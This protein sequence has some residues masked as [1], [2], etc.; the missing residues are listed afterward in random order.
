MTPVQ[1]INKSF[2]NVDG[3]LKH[4]SINTRKCKHLAPSSTPQ[5]D[6]T[7]SLQMSQEILHQ[8]GNEMGMNVDESKNINHGLCMQLMHSFLYAS[9]D[10]SSLNKTIK[11]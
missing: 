1:K 6:T 8:V 2:D 5:R 9:S 11:L 3:L 7:F 10:I 4:T